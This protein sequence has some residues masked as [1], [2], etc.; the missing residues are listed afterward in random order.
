MVSKLY[1]SKKGGFL[2]SFVHIVGVASTRLKPLPT[3]LDLARSARLF[4]TPDII[5]FVH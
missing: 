4:A 5:A 1:S 2:F 3:S